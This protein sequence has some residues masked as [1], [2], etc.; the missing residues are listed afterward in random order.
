MEKT[1]TFTPQPVENCIKYVLSCGFTLIS[2][3][4]W[5]YTFKR[6]DT[7]LSFSLNELRDAYM[8]GF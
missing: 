4:N 2:R 5:T 1:R 8:N 6:G 7:T 3:K